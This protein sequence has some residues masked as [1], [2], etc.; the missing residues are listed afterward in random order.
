MFAA[1][2]AI[3]G[4]VTM[5]LWNALITPLF[6]LPAI[7]FWQA[8]G[9]LVLSRLLVGGLGSHAHALSHFFHH[10]GHGHDRDFHSPMR[11][12]RER[13]EGMKPEDRIKL[14]EKFHKF[15]DEE[16]GNI[17]EHDDVTKPTQEP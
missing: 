2:L 13:W 3:F 17:T 6:T 5:L 10:R 11:E 12:M 15:F 14:H 1:T 9:F 8:L 4:L 7:N 16:H